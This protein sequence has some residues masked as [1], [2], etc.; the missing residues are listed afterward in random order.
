MAAQ[1]TNTTASTYNKLFQNGILSSQ[2][3]TLTFNVTP[4]INCKN[5][6]AKEEKQPEA[7]AKQENNTK[8]SNQKA[9]IKYETTVEGD[10]S[11]EDE[12][13]F[14]AFFAKTKKG[15]LDKKD[16]YYTSLYTEILSDVIKSKEL[17][18]TIAQDLKTGL[19]QA[20]ISSKKG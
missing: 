7:P 3:Q 11:P 9:V 19:E 12:E 1:P 13:L 20:G 10:V 4:S 14:K 17:K 2:N 16:T 15:L 6:P 8:Q 5:K 18:A